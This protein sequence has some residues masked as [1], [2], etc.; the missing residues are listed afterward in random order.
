VAWPGVEPDPLA[1]APT[2]PESFTSRQDEVVRL[3]VVGGLPGAGKS[4]LADAL[5]EQLHVGV[6]NK[7]RI[8]ASLWRGG[9]TAS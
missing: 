7:D 4:F 2:E 6:F 5:A 3:V 1:G 8:E 9:V